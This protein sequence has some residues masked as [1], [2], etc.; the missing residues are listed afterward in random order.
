MSQIT[1]HQIKQ[2]MLDLTDGSP[3]YD[4]MWNRIR[5]E[6]ERR[7]SGWSEH[8]DALPDKSVL[9]RARQWTLAAAAAVVVAAAGGTA[10][11]FDQQTEVA[12]T[13]MG[14]KIE[15]SA[16]AEG[17]ELTLNSVA[18][19]VKPLEQ[20]KQMA[21]HL[22]LTDTKKQGFGT[23]EFEQA[24]LTD[25]SSGQQLAVSQDKRSLFEFDEGSGTS[26]LTQSFE[27]RLPVDGESR[28]YRL[29]LKNP[30]YSTAQTIDSLQGDWTIE[31]TVKGEQA[32]SATYT[33]PIEDQATFEDRTGMKLGEAQIS[34]FDIR[35]P[36]TRTQDSSADSGEFMYYKNS[37][38]K[39]DNIGLKGQWTPLPGS[40]Q[41]QLGLDPNAPETLHFN[42]VD[43]SLEDVRDSSLTLQLRNA[44]IQ[45][46]YP[47][48][49]TP[50]A[51]PGEKVQ[52]ISETLPDQNVI[53]YKV[54][55][56]GL[57]I[58]VNM[59]IKNDLSMISGTRIQVDG[60]TYKR[61]ESESYSKYTGDTGFQVD[62]F[63]NVPEGSEFSINMG[64]YGVYDSSRDI[65]VQ[66]R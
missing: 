65:D 18:I 30:T 66:I 37:T 23:V 38:L 48:I 34:P 25:L 11:Y 5:L 21:L 22:R 10:V 57:D 56:E 40:A 7:R 4:E 19:G 39:V 26:T 58:H 1:E 47:D 41:I 64:T 14:Q 20:E 61:S 53:A 52:S 29:T 9:S 17:I 28:E 42:L 16:E 60:K 33:V 12:P 6:V 49:W 8:T 45:R 44:V 15:A 31:F 50:M 43:N 62:V 13:V 51:P 2:K 35:I 59:P 54:K 46:S 24:I 32:A 63:K 3:N 36:V 55:R 27:G